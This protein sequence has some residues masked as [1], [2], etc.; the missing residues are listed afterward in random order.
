MVIDIVIFSAGL[1]LLSFGAKWLVDGASAITLGFGIRPVIVGMSVVAFGTSMPEFVFNIAATMNNSSDLGLG[2][3]VGSN[4]ANIAL[5]L[6]VSS[7]IKPLEIN[8]KVVKKE[9][10]ITIAVTLLF[11]FMALDGQISSIDGGIL[12]FLFGLFFIYLIKNGQEYSED[13]DID[14]DL[15][16]QVS[17]DIEL[18]PKNLTKDIV[19]IIVG[20][21][22]LIGGAQL[23][24]N[25]SINIAK[26]FNIS[27]L[28]IGVTIVAIGTSLPELAA[29]VVSSFKAEG[30]ISLGNVLGS[31][32]FNILMVIG[33]LS[34]FS[35]VLAQGEFTISL[36]F[37]FMVALTLL[38]WPILKFS[39]K[40]TRVHGVFLIAVYLV[41][42]YLS[43]TFV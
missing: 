35:P 13:L 27:E 40:I 14:I 17:P 11:L 12:V 41:Y 16:E 23:M 36:H 43:Y 22:G 21:V 25:S 3:I 9:L 7:L 10:P 24:V 42:M 38:I 1:L 33:F 39:A 8:Q 5:V 30:D 29:S 32:I 37:T 6:G 19:L 18:T 4:I 2:N 26:V 28:V 34:L 31:N 20:L 15:D